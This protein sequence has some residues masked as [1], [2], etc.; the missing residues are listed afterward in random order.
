MKESRSK[1]EDERYHSGPSKTCSSDQVGAVKLE[2]AVGFGIYFKPLFLKPGSTIKSL[3][4]LLRSTDAWAVPT[5]TTVIGL[6]RA[7]G[8]WDALSLPGVSGSAR[9]ETLRSEELIEWRGI[10]TVPSRLFLA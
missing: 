9:S 2:R 7:P 6:G 10:E 4:E 8:Y 1:R 5:E 3:G